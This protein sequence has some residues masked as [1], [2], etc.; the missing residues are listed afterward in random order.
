MDRVWV[1]QNA[2]VSFS[3][4]FYNV[5][6]KKGMNQSCMQML[7]GLTMEMTDTSKRKPQHI[8]KTCIASDEVTVKI[9][10]QNY[11]KLMG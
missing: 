5:K 9:D 11:R 10:A 6:A 1:T 2:G 8:L 3:K 4:S 7:N